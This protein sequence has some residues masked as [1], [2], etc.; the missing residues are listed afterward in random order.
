MF[1]FSKGGNTLKVCTKNMFDKT[2]HLSNPNPVTNVL[3]DPRSK[4]IVK[5][6]KG[7]QTTSKYL[8]SFDPLISW[9]NLPGHKDYT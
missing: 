2:W 7:N 4:S 6:T 8:P 9:E 5:K 3:Q 1:L